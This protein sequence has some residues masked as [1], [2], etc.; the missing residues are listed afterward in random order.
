VKRAAQRRTGPGRRTAAERAAIDKRADAWV[1]PP[2]AAQLI[3]LA[4]LDRGRLSRSKG[5]WQDRDGA[6]VRAA[7]MTA[8]PRRGLVKIHGR[9]FAMITPA[10]RREFTRRG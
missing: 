6:F 8:L 3:V 9:R 2:S 5:G 7:T 10:G 1:R 4:L